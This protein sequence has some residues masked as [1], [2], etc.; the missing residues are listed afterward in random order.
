MDEWIE[1]I[2]YEGDVSKLRRYGLGLGEGSILLAARREDRLVLDDA[3]AR[4]FAESKGL[5]FTGLIGLLV[6]AVRN[7][8]LKREKGTEVLNKLAR[9]DFRIS[10]DL[11]LWAKGEI[12]CVP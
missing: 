5:R 8:K 1:V 2:N 12:E 4:R 11:L 9:S 7:K 10:S 6:A 3:N